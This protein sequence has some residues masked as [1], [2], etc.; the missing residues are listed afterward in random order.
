MTEEVYKNWVKLLNLSRKN[1]IALKHKNFN[2]EINNLF[3]HSYYSK[4]RNYVKFI[5]IVS[6]KWKNWRSSR[7]PPST[8]LQ[9]EDWSRIRTLSWNLLV[10]CRNCRMKLIA[11]MIQEIFRILNQSAV[12]IPTLPVNLCLSHLIQFL[13]GMLSRSRGMPSRREGPPSSWETF[14]QIQLRPLQHLIRRNWIHGVPEQQSRFTHPQWKRVRIK[15]QFKIR[16]ANLDRLPEIH[17]SSVRKIFKELWGR[18]TTT[19]DFRSSFGQTHHASTSRLLEEK[20]QDWGMY[21]FRISYGSY[22]VDQ[23]S[24]IGLISGWPQIFVF[25]K[26]NSN[27]RFCTRR[28]ACFSTYPDHP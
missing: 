4:I 18:P 26:R 28:G 1:F 6:V 22:A 20:I 21:L 27:A 14:L 16:D 9:D 11:W 24:G 7:V 10:R 25:R 23:R 15:H 8:L 19:A 17:S 3:M 2:D 12:D 13:V 5:I